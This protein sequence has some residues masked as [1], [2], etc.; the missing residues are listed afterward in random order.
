M[1]ILYYTLIILA[2]LVFIEPASILVIALV[3]LYISLLIPA[4]LV[5]VSHRTG[6]LANSRLY[7]ALDWYTN[8]A[9]D[10]VDAINQKFQDRN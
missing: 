5:T 6:R 3:L 9:M 7:R 10:Q 8:W 1:D 2:L 4:I